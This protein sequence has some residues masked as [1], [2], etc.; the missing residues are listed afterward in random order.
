MNY[1]N[2]GGADTM[3]AGVAQV[4]AIFGPFIP[5]LIWLSRRREEPVSARE[6]ATATNFGMFVFVVFV[7]A[8]TVRLFVPWL[9]V[10]GTVGQLAIVASAAVL[11]VQ[12]YSSV[13]KGV[14]A[15]YPIDIKVVKI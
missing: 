12:A 9:G 8:T 13:H 1:D 4:G 14:P 6:A 2:L 7:A 11:C 15:T 5:F 3:A 10:L